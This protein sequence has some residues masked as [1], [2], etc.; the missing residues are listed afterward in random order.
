M[1]K[2]IEEAIALRP[3]DL[4]EHNILHIR[5]VIYERSVVE[6]EQHEYERIPL[7]SP[8][9]AELVRRLRQLG[10]GHDWIFRTRRGTPVDP[11][12][13]LARKLHPAAKAI[14]IKVGGWHDFRHTFTTAMRRAGV[15]AK[16]LSKVLG[17]GKSTGNLAL[18]V[19]DHTDDNDI[20]KALAMGANWLMQ[21]DAIQSALLANCQMFPQM[22]PDGPVQQGASSSS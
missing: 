15:H 6:F 17:H 18:D 3:S 1:P 13:G 5:R 2:R 8:I 21:E 14:G 4:D 10:E 9:H 16:V 7:D 20:R 11:H 12:N 22:C 19:Y